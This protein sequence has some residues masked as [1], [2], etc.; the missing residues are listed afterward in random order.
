MPGYRGGK[1]NKIQNC[2]GH[3]DMYSGYIDWVEDKEAFV[4]KA[5]DFYKVLSDFNM[6]AREK[7]LEGKR[8]VL[9]WGMG[10]IHICKSGT[11][12]PRRKTATIDWPASVKAGKHVYYTNLHSDGYRYKIRWQFNQTVSPL[13]KYYYLIPA[14]HFKRALAKIVKAR[15]TDYFQ[16]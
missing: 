11:N 5:E 1:P 12:T 13:V 15:E 10:W 16:L 4:L 14:R 8:F 7:L 2:H 9:P 6:I 3:K